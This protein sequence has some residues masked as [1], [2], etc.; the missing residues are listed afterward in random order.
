MPH[1]TFIHGISN[2]PPEKQLK[3]ISLEAMANNFRGNNDSIALGTA[4][5]RHR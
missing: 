2:K 1:I 3:K 4:G 5:S